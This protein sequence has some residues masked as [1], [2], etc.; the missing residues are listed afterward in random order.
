MHRCARRNRSLA[1]AVETFECVCSALQRCRAA[2]TAARADKAIRP[3]PFEQERGAARLVGKSLLE[4]RKRARLGH[5]VIR[6]HP[7]RRLSQ[8]AIPHLDIP[9]MSPFRPTAT[10]G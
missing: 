7:L 3:S 5:G 2:G 1:S 4:L 6:R 10:S 8:A 9:G